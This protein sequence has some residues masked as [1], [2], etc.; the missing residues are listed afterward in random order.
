MEPLIRLSARVA[1]LPRSDI[2]TDI[3]FPA[4]FL[5]ITEKRG[6]GRYAFFD[7][8]TANDGALPWPEVPD[9]P[10]RIL[11][12]GPN[13][14]CGSS[15]EQAVWA[16][17]DLGLKVIIA[18]GFG[19]IFEANCFKNG[20]LPI[21]LDQAVLD[22][23]VAETHLTVDLESSQIRPATGPAIPFAVVDWRRDAL[24]NGWDEVLTL[25]NTKS[26]AI[27][28]FETSRRAAAPWLF[29]HQEE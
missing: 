20:I 3:I 4:R 8:R 16:L 13:F 25:I 12:A 29:G 28:A 24:M 26:A 9:D 22:G 5:L 23:L 14:G 15:R 19:E 18:P 11:I 21:R 7:W 27:A 10:P 17:G 2:D 1:R 6:L